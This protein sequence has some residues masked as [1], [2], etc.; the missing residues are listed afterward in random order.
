M[1]RTLV[2]ALCVLGLCTNVIAEDGATARHLLAGVHAFKD[3]RYA[4][5]LVELRVVA[6]APDAPD[7]L[8]FYLGPTLYKLGR[9]AEALDVFVTSRAAADALT[10]F[11]RGQT[12]YQLRMFRKARATFAALRSGGLGPALDD[13]AGRYVDQVD[14][15]Y[16]SSPAIDAIDYYIE[17]GL[18]LRARDPVLAAEYLDEARQV[19][20]LS[21]VRHRRAEIADALAALGR[22]PR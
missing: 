9:Y 16:R 19:E 13:A 10:D 22:A 18:D 15:A 2:I 3:G 5:A 7:D 8:A 12:Y 6:R 20:A 1:M 17:Q 21:P 4:E 11:Y 14:A